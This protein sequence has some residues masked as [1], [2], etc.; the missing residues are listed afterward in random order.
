[1][2]DIKLFR[3]DPEKIKDDL[4]KR[5]AEAR[6]KEV[7]KLVEKDKKWREL[8][9]ETDQ[10]KHKRNV[11][12]QK[13]GEKK[14][15]GKNAQE[16]IQKSKDLSKKIESLEEEMKCLRKEI[17]KKLMNLPNLLHP[18]VPK[19]ESDEDN[20]EI[21][22]VGE[23]EIPD[24][25][26]YSHGEVIE[27][28]GKGDFDRA[29]KVSGQGFV[30]LLED[31]VLL[32]YALL[33]YGLK[34]MIEQ[35][36]T[37]VEPPFMMRREPYE[38][39]VDLSDFEDVMYK[40]EGEDLYL[41]AT[42]EHP[43]AAMHKDEILSEEELPKK[44]VG[45]SPCFR[46]EIGSHG[47]DTKGLFR[48]HQFNK[49]EQ[50]IF[51][52]PENSWDLH[53][54]LLENAEELLKNLDIPYR[55]VNVCTGDIGTVAAKKYDIEAWSPRQEKYIEVVSCSNCTDYQARRLNIRVGKVGAGEKEV[56]HTLNST[57]LATSR[58]I[59]SILE[60]NQQE[61]GSVKIPKPLQEY[62]GGKEYIKTEE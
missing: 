29:T 44:L 38:G 58:T 36:Y 42:S 27:N 8:K 45:V 48:M 57:A 51:S 41:I 52:K 11:L 7:D 55:V 5:G 10:L 4:R 39:T 23:P 3:E 62:M 6:S 12:S 31:L 53:E 15:E 18:S 26:L 2:L 28:M 30:Y 1:M 40:I 20:E 9:R 59:V 14:S 34:Y 25:A 24:Y 19:G 37:P 22:R 46:R 13:I 47:V 50:F 61:D 54:E 35:G 33:N 56:V 16:Q 43:L 17:D 49:I 60:N 21:Y 32:D